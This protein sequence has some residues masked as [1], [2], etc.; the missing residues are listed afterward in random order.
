MTPAQT[1]CVTQLVIPIHTHGV[2]G[3]IVLPRIR[4]RAEQP[5]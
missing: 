2:A 4:A 5:S 1:R 3:G